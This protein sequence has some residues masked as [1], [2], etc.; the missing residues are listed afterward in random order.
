MPLS[1]TIKFIL[2]RPWLFRVMRAW[3]DH[4][5]RLSGYRKIGLRQDDLINEENELV[6]QALQR[7]PEREKCDRVFRIRRAVQLDIQ[8]KIL[9][10]SEWTKPHEDWP[11]LSMIVEQ[12][13]AEQ[14][15]KDDLDSITV[16]KRS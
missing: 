15:E 2:Q 4:W 1:P 6:L 3:S 14:K 13:E 10:E 16:M 8:K 7:L 12:L 5:V 11:Y 9:P